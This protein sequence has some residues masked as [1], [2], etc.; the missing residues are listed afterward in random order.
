MNVPVFSFD[1]DMQS[2]S[3]IAPCYN[4]ELFHVFM[5]MRGHL[6]LHSAT[7][8][9]KLAQDSQQAW[10]AVSQLAALCYLL[11]YQVETLWP[12]ASQT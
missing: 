8:L 5:E 7:L 11:A 10:R 12:A 2:L 6:Y 3:S 9:L 4:D 1:K